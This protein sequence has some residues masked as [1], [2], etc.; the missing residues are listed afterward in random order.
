MTEHYQRLTFSDRSPGYI[1]LLFLAFFF[2]FNDST[3]GGYHRASRRGH[4]GGGSERIRHT[5]PQ[6]RGWLSL[7]PNSVRRL[8]LRR[9]LEQGSIQSVSSFQSLDRLGRGVGGGT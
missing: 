5:Y 8:Q 4:V 9:H 2:L 7:G 1:S 6:R 3:N